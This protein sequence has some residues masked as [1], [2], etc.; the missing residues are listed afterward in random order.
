MIID[1]FAFGNMIVKNVLATPAPSIYAASSIAFGIPLKNWLKI[2]MYNP[3][4]REVPVIDVKINGQYEFS[5][6]TDSPPLNKGIIPPKLKSLKFIYIGIKIV[7]GGT[8]MVK[9]TP[10]NRMLLPLNRSLAKA[11]PASA[12][13]A[14]VKIVVTAANMNVLSNVSQ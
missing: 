14:A 6:F 3:A 7:V 8:I 12:Q 13:D 2:K 10:R 11:Y 1:D 5:K 4:L 9:I